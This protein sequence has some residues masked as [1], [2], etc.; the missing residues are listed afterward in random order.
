MAWLPIHAGR[1]A[2]ISVDMSPNGIFQHA[3]VGPHP[4][5]TATGT[6]LWQPGSAGMVSLTSH[7]P[8]WP[9]PASTSPARPHDSARPAQAASGT[10]ADDRGGPQP[11]TTAEQQ[12]RGPAAGTSGTPDASSRSG[13]PSDAPLPRTDT[14]EL[15][16][17]GGRQGGPAGEA[18]ARHGGAAYGYVLSQAAGFAAGARAHTHGKRSG[19]KGVQRCGI[20]AEDGRTD[21]PPAT[22]EHGGPKGEAEF[23]N[24][25]HCGRASM[26][27][28]G[29]VPGP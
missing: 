23:A 17:V 5:Q 2:S 20:V 29:R 24:R 4:K 16:P 22:P 13:R 28:I 21:S 18:L 14:H 11:R 27:A 12:P 10:R 9:G 26:V 3:P 6:S 19:P 7:P 25:C 1:R 8:R 15:G